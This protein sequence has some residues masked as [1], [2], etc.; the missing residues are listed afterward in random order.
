MKTE[1]RRNTS[2][3]RLL[4]EALEGRRLLT[5]AAPNPLD[6]ST[7]D[8]SNGFRVDGEAVDSDLGTIVAGA[9]D[10]NG[11]GLDDFVVSAVTADAESGSAY[12]V[13]GSA[14]VAPEWNVQN[15]DGTNGFQIRDSTRPTDF[16][17]AYTV[18]AAGDVNGDGFDDVV[19]GDRDYDEGSGGAWVLYGR[20]EFGASFD[21]SSIDPVSG[22][23]VLGTPIVD[24]VGLSVGSVGDINGDGF[25]DVGIDLLPRGQESYVVHVVFGQPDRQD[26]TIFFGS[27]GNGEGVLIQGSKT[28]LARGFS[29]GGDVNGDGFDDVLIDRQ[30]DDSATRI[31]VAPALVFGAADFP[32][33]TIRTNE[34]DGQN[35]FRILPENPLDRICG[36]DLSGD[37]NGDGLNDIVVTYPSDEGE[38]RI[39]FGSAIGFPSEFNLADLDGSTGFRVLGERLY[40]ESGA[41]FA[42]SASFVGDVNADGFDDIAFATFNSV[43]NNETTSS[44]VLF[45][46]AGSDA[47]VIDVSS[48]DGTNGFRMDSPGRDLNGFFPRDFFDSAGRSVSGAGDFN[49]DGF[50]DVLIGAQNAHGTLDGESFTLYTGAAYVVFGG[51]FG[52]S[53]EGVLRERRQW[54][55]VCLRNR[56]T[57]R[58][59]NQY[60]GRRGNPRRSSH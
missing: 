33:L 16:A 55:I 21:L 3:R 7:L 35:G 56:Q 54:C 5:A 28:S 15:L 14:S 23:R 17:Y 46:R 51:D 48:F 42:G 30:I 1:P 27:P 34:M 11:D 8:G 53:Y 49:G 43:G 60:G 19:L 44:Y 18:G 22:Y 45:G 12:V 29:A 2:R 40:E 6:L 58:I 47:A 57:R 13:F 26:S 38:A 4:I 9:G 24:E 10:V 20:S 37:F 41:G 52:A 32:A 31:E 25:D 36:A 39:I 50:S 59:Q